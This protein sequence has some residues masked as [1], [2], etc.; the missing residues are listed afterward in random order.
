MFGGFLGS[1][2]KNRKERCK[3]DWHKLQQI[4][5]SL[6]EHGMPVLADSVDPDQLACLDMHCLSLNL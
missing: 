2:R 4:N 6:A 1:R 3:N 5:L